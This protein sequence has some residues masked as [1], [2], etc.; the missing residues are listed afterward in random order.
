[1][2]NLTRWLGSTE[3]NDESGLATFSAAGR[4]L[5]IRLQSFADAQAMD[6]VIGDAEKLAAER[7]RHTCAR[8]LRGAAANMESGT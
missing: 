5:V 7:A 3:P 8:Y 1:M 2:S 6:A 4:V